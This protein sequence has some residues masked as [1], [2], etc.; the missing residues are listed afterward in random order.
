MRSHH[1]TLRVLPDAFAICRLDE[2]SKIP[3]WA[4]EGGLHSVTRTEEELSI[5][6]AEEYVPADVRAERGWRC[7]KVQG[8]FAF[9]EIGVL[10]SLTAPLAEAGISLLAIS[11]FD[12]DYLLVKA[13]DL[14]NAQRVL[15]AA[16]HQ[17]L[18]S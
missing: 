4:F 10:A 15:T 16:G 9:S 6:C 7:L 17:L 18:A 3:Q 1:L 5:V 13:P 11:T 14:A 2:N 8:P 12:T